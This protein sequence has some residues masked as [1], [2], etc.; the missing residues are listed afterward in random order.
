MQRVGLSLQPSSII[1]RFA[2]GERRQA[3][4]ISA[5]NSNTHVEFSAQVELLRA[6]Y[7]L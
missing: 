4:L 1:G 6:D 3:R 7:R 2:A 5:L